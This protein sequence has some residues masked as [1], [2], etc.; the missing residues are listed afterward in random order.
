ML[1]K[2]YL[3][4]DLEMAGYDPVDFDPV[5]IKTDRLVAKVREEI[6]QKNVAR[7]G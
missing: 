6:R 7:L 5:R 1:D 2:G 3:R 4:A